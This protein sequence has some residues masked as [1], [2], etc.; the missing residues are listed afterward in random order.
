MEGA[1][2]GQQ[3]AQE[4]REKTEAELRLTCNNV[5]SLLEKFLIPSASQAESSILFEN[6]RR[7]LLL[8]SGVAAGDDQKG[9]V[10]QSQQRYQKFLKSG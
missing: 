8:L 6:E 9:I 10:G 7:L 5:L 4:H 1:E 2:T 3:M